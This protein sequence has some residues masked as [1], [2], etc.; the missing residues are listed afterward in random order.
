MTYKSL[1]CT[2]ALSVAIIGLAAP[3]LA[4]ST[5]APTGE[6]TAARGTAFQVS[7]DRVTNPKGRL[8]KATVEDKNG[9]SVGAVHD[10]VVDRD[11][12]PTLIR[13]NVGGF[14]GMGTKLIELKATELKYEQDRNVLITTLRKPQI[15]AMPAINT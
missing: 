9:N 13:V 15:E 2:T 7:L 14:L 12:R 10:V 4:A 1:L 8:A 3:A 5:M 11:G 6:Q